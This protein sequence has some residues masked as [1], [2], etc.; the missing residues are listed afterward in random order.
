MLVTSLAS[1]L[2]YQRE[3]A[4]T[5]EH[6]A[7]TRA[8]AVAGKV[9]IRDAFEIGRRE[10]LT[11]PRDARKLRHDIADM[12]SKMRHELDRS[13]DAPWATKQGKGDRKSVVEG[14]SV[15]VR[16]DIGVRRSITKKKEQSEKT[17]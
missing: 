1:F 10:I 13:S 3:S 14:Q 5:W 6:Q 16:I 11:Q 15:S 9:Q 12:R 17:T 8:R 2:G 7:L 4:W